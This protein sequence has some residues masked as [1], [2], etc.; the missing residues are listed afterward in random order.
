MVIEELRI[1]LFTLVMQF[2]CIVRVGNLMGWSEKHISQCAQ[3]LKGQWFFGRFKLS[4][5][6]P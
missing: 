3:A 4:T 5:S 6:V 1:F 2:W